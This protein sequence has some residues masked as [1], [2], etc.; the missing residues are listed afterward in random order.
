[1]KKGLLITFFVA[2]FGVFGWWL[3]THIEW[4]EKSNW[5]GWQ[6]EAIHNDWL[7]AEWFIK[8]MGIPAR[9][10]SNPEQLNELPATD[11]ILIIPTNR[12]TFSQARNNALLDWVAAGG[13]LLIKAQHLY[14]EDDFEYDPIADYVD[15]YPQYLSSSETEGTAGTTTFE[16]EGS[17]DLLEV[18]F[19]DYSVLEYEEE[20][21]LLRIGNVF[22]DHVISVPY[23]QGLITV[24]SDINWMKNLNIGDH[25]HARL[26]LYL[27][28]LRT[29]PSEVLILKSD[30]IPPLWEWLWLINPWAVSLAGLLLLLWL[31]RAP[32]RFGPLLPADDAPRRRILEHIQ[33]AAYYLW[34]HGQSEVLLAGLRND[35]I[36]RAIQV[37]PEI[38]RLSEQQRIHRL[39]EITELPAEQI[40]QALMVNQPR[41]RPAFLQQ[42]NTLETIRKQL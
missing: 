22:G 41:N 4:Y 34:K 33:A 32:W 13:H 20:Q 36:Y 27:L 21:E 1:M 7:A 17:S 26:L 39:A 16:I 30:D 14:D 35:L 11:S 40:H 18:A 2:L 23:G 24:V 31:W 3:S 19:N 29:T 10:L 5:Q 8:S 28:N 37:H 9:T 15:V 42:V 6:G 38:Q 12:S 25:G